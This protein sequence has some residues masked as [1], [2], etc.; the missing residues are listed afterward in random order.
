MNAAAHVRLTDILGGESMPRRR[1]QMPSV[2]KR[3]DVKRA[4]WYTRYRVDVIE[5][6]GALGRQHK[7]KFLGYCPTTNDPV[8]RK[9]RGGLQSGKPSACA[10]LSWRRSTESITC[11]SHKSS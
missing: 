7:H 6:K 11:C 3:D 10:T 2:R 4:Y 8:E 9:R 5:S 1:F